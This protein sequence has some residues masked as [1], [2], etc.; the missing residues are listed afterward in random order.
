MDEDDLRRI[1]AFPHALIG[2]DGLPHDEKPHP[3]LW[4]TFPRVLGHYSRDVGLFPLEEAVH[5][6]TGVAANVFRIE[7]RGTLATG[8]YADITLFDEDT[9]IDVAD[10]TQPK[11]PATGIE[12]VMVNGR[13]VWRHGEWTGNRPGR[14]HRRA[15]RPDLM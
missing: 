10:Y 7:D 11:R 9:V 13:A 3:R 5:R 1:M 15:T 14:L 2:S 6:M 4:G 12:M 8:A